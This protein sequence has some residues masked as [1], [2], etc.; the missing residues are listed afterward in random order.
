M[1]RRILI[2]RNKCKHDRHI[3]LTVVF[4][5]TDLVEEHD[6]DYTGDNSSVVTYPV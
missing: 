6:D 3:E 4:E 5:R 2:K 1:S